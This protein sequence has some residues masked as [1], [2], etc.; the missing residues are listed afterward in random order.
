MLRGLTLNGFYRMGL[1]KQVQ[2]G[3]ITL[4]GVASATV[5]I[6]PVVMENTIVHRLGATIDL[7]ADPSTMFFARLSLASTT[8]V[9][10]DLFSS[11]GGAITI[12]SYE[13]IEFYPGVLRVQRG[14][15]TSGATSATTAINAVVMGKTFV[16]WLGHTFE[17]TGL[18]WTSYSPYH[19]MARADLSSPTTMRQNRDPAGLSFPATTGFEVVE[20]L[21]HGVN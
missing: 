20:I 18:P 10:A 9:R 2:R 11:G 17:N 13:V 3:T 8:T 16:N 1:I 4:S 12:V 19:M 21:M 7:S 5:P 14:T 6:N 15:I